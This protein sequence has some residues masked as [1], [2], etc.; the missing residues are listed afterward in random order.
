MD[1]SDVAG[2]LNSLLRRSDDTRGFSS[3]SNGS[4]GPVGDT[5]KPR[6]LHAGPLLIR[7]GFLGPKL[8]PIGSAFQP[9]TGVKLRQINE[10]V[11]GS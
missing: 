10:S 9:K 8:G 11:D 6:F 1:G 5:K 2:Q 4:E 3:T 7:T